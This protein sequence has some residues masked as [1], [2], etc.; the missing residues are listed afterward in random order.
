M[1]IIMQ[2]YP[3]RFTQK[4]ADYKLTFL[5]L[6]FTC[7]LVTLIPITHGAEQDPVLIVLYSDTDDDILFPIKADIG[8]ITN[9][10]QIDVQRV[11]IHTTSMG[12]TCAVVVDRDNRLHSAYDITEPRAPKYFDD[13]DSEV[14]FTNY[15]VL[16]HILN[17]TMGLNITILIFVIIALSIFVLMIKISRIEKKPSVSWITKFQKSLF[18]IVFIVSLLILCVVF[19]AEEL[20]FTLWLVDE[21]IPKYFNSALDA[22]KAISVALTFFLL[23]NMYREKY[24]SVRLQKLEQ[25]L[26]LMHQDIKKHPCASKK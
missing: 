8:N 11:E 19:F 14:C 10:A 26:D 20:I 18:K 4:L 21:P 6:V 2:N 13:I 25:K 12:K 15:N 5:A 1:L 23:S 9:M 22:I 24:Y 16:H 7:G 3:W 17:S